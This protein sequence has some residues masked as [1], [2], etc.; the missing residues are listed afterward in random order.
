MITVTIAEAMETTIDTTDHY[1][2]R[3]RSEEDIFYVGRSLSPI[4]RLM[5]HLGKDRPWS[6][7]RIG[8]LIREQFPASRDWLMEMYTLED[9]IPFIDEASLPFYR[10]NLQNLLVRDSLI[11]EAENCMIYRFEPYLNYINN[12]NKKKRLPEKYYIEGQIANEGVK[13]D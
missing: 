5:Q 3:Y 13:L 4:D 11:Q 6:P 10:A 8:T 9:C 12:A 7:D 1:L 2:Y